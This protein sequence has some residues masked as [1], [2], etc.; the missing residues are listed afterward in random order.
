MPIVLRI[1]R[2]ITFR[3]MV[4]PARPANQAF[5]FVDVRQAADH[6]DMESYK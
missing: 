4:Q 6:E 5:L 3:L 2:T 1:A